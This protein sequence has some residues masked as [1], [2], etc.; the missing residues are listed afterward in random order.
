VSLLASSISLCSHQPAYL[1]NYQPTNQPTNG[2]FAFVHTPLPQA[3]S[4]MN[5]PSSNARMSSSRMALETAP[6]LWGHPH[7]QYAPLPP[8]HHHHSGSGSSSNHLASGGGAA[9][10]AAVT[11]CCAFLPVAERNS[12]ALRLYR[13]GRRD[14]ATE[15][16]MG[17]LMELESV[18]LR[19]QLLPPSCSQSAAAA[20]APFAPVLLPLPH[21]PHSS[22]DGGYNNGGGLF[23]TTT[24]TA[25]S[26]AT[27]SVACFRDLY[28]LMARHT[29][30][31]SPDT[32]PLSYHRAATASPV[33]SMA[34]SSSSSSSSGGNHPPAAASP[35]EGGGL[36]QEVLHYD[37]A[38]VLT[39]DLPCHVSATAAV[40]LYNLALMLHQEAIASNRSCCY[41]NAA[42]MYSQAIHL[43]SLIINSSSSSHN[44]SD[45]NIDSPQRPPSSSPS[46]LSTGTGST[47]LR[48]VLAASL[49]NLA[50][51]YVS[52]FAD[53]R[54][55]AQCQL[56]L[57]VL[58][59][60]AGRRSGPVGRVPAELQF[61]VTSLALTLMCEPRGGMCAAPAA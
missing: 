18:R 54:S 50:C 61:F 51:C 4:I 6:A 48:T 60:Q 42:R 28:L 10:A 43:L 49:H 16:L 9:A 7:P 23:L 3:P 40:L 56:H 13:K 5:H 37:N 41:E 58:L 17:A 45:P 29:T 38:F 26:D 20:A 24:R 32:H 52:G 21:N 19:L 39:G 31:T 11:T 57:A 55:A 30:H 47:T 2:K 33:L 22:N 25:A 34:S 1:P 44:N 15:C 35:P 36:V 53:L 14:D 12:E 8:P 59:T 27:N 46:I